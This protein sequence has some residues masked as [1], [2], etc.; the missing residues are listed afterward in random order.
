MEKKLKLFNKGNI[1]FIT[2]LVIAVSSSFFSCSS[3]KQCEEG[4]D[5]SHISL[6]VQIERLDKQIRQISSPQDLK[7]LI[8]SNPDL[9]N[10]FS[11]QQ[12]PND[13]VFYQE[14]YEVLKN[15]YVDT[16]F[17]DIERVYNDLSWM[18]EEFEK[19]FR[20]I[21]AYYPGFKVPK[22]KTIASGFFSPDFYFTDSIIYIG[23][24]YFTGPTGHYPPPK[25]PEYIVKRYRKEYIVPTAVRIIT[26]TFNATDITDKTML[27]EMIYWGKSYYFLNKVLLCTPDSLIL[28]YSEK[29]IRASVANQERIWAHFVDKQL[30]Y[31]TSHF[32]K[33]KYIGD[34]PYTAEI[35]SKIP[36]RIGQWLGWKIVNKFMKEKDLTL[37]ELMSIRS[38]PRIL[39][40]SRFKPKDG[41]DL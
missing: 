41:E 10:V 2:F 40:E 11:I 34:R 12:Y 28:G 32:I 17:Q 14:F 27:A 9:R 4:P 24:D 31:E 33:T 22:I 37:Q 39:N 19:A 20:N 38:A 35:S 36:G 30:F 1:I 13:S 8:S 5:V 23:L 18:E 29:Q 3:D 7:S 21:K 26:S 15:A 25:E 16:V 6:D